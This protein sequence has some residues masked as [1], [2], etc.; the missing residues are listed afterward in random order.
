M[1]TAKAGLENRLK[2]REQE[3]ATLKGKA[4]ELEGA[5]RGVEG[6]HEEALAERERRAGRLRARVDELLEAQG[7]LENEVAQGHRQVAVAKN[8]LGLYVRKCQN[9]EAELGQARAA[10]AHAKV[11]ISELKES[12]KDSGPKN[13]Y[14]KR[15]FDDMLNQHAQEIA[16]L[17]TTFTK[18]VDEI[19]SQLKKRQDEEN[20]ALHEKVAKLTEALLAA[21]KG[22]DDL[23][24]WSADKEAR[25][26][27]VTGELQALRKS[28]PSIFQ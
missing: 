17:K 11:A 27:H 26:P 23:N 20:A 3:V 10:L 13:M 1:R 18:Q 2:A 7:R 28:A 4:D 22:S 25:T 21:Q 16:R 6:R 8:E 15:K 14:N 9:L 19:Q 24:I 12:S 5:L